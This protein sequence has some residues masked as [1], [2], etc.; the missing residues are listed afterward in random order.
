MP[1]PRAQ[2]RRHKDTTFFN[3]ANFFLLFFHIFEK[4][5]DIFGYPD[6]YEHYENQMKCIH[7][8]KTAKPIP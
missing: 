4:F 7:E 1:K 6:G 5:H 2:Y 8:K 3:T